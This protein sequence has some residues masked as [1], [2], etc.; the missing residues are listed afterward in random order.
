[1]G[2]AYQK[3]IE[4]QKTCEFMKHLCESGCGEKIYIKDKENHI[5]KC[6]NYTT[7]CPKCS[8]SY[9]PNK[10]NHDCIESMKIYVNDLDD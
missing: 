7:D 2:L 3:A 5:S 1:M 10:G 4:H 6:L 9:Q 8:I